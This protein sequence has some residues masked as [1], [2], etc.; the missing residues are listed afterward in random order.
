MEDLARNLITGTQTDLILLDFSKAFDKVSHLKLL[1]KLKMHGID[2]NALKWIQSFLIGR[3]QTV[4]LEG[5]I[6]EELTVTSGVPQWSVLGPILFLLYI[7]DLPENIQSQVR[8]F[9]VDTAV[10][11]VVGKQNNPQQLQDDLD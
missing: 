4:I 3:T 10:Y 11:L 9:A 5:Q 6:S 8:L 7:N 2:G 1:F